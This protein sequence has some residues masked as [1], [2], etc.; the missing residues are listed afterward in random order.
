[1]IALNLPTSEA[2]GDVQGKVFEN[3]GEH[4]EGEG[5]VQKLID[6][7]DKHYR[8]DKITRVI[9]KI[10]KLMGTKR[11]KGQAERQRGHK[12]S[13]VLPHVPA[14]GECGADRDRVADDHG[15]GQHTR[16][17]HPV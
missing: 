6:W 11:K 7:L 13:P 17:G 1:M 5:G 14:H 10:R 4:L 9:E 3:L 8:V 16:H 15:R 12:A 2:E